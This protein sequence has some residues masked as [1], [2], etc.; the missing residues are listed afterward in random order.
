MFVLSMDTCFAV[1]GVAG[2]ESTN[3]CQFV[4]TVINPTILLPNLIV[5]CE[6]PLAKENNFSFS[7]PYLLFN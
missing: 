1:E 7:L 2:L 3:S 4:G 5:S 6:F